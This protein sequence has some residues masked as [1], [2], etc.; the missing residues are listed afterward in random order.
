MALCEYILNIT[1]V[2]NIYDGWWIWSINLLLTKNYW[3]SIIYQIVDEWTRTCCQKLNVVL[4]FSF[5]EAKS[6]R[7]IIS[8]GE[9]MESVHANTESEP[10]VMSF[11]C[12]CVS[13]MFTCVQSVCSP[14]R[15]ALYW[16]GRQTESEWPGLDCTSSPEGRNAAV[17]R[18]RKTDRDTVM[19]YWE[20]QF[21][22]NTQNTHKECQAYLSERTELHDDPHRVL[23]DHADQLD[24]VRVVKLTHCHCRENT[25]AHISLGNYEVT[26][27]RHVKCVMW[28]VCVWSY[29]LLEGTSLWHCLR[30][31][32]YRS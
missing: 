24:N 16:A 30:Y 17:D 11:F 32:S 14:N 27:L 28:S 22:R 15:P 1:F 8:G 19:S 31:S 5:L 6:L 23:C 25:H 26:F 29:V 18:E 12:V 20:T 21:Y 9:T 2:F 3:V 13:C 10:R 4:L 7:W